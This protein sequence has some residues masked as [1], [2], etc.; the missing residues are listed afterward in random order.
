M[1]IH[2][3]E[4]SQGR[5]DRRYASEPVVIKQ[6]R[7]KFSFSK[8]PIFE[9]ENSLEFHTEFA[10]MASDRMIQAKNL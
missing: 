4:G 2:Q 7:E 3:Y 1:I 10:E 6:P 8:K 5:K 9:I